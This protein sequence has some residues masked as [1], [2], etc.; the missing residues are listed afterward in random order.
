[1]RYE[2]EGLVIVSLFEIVASLL[3]LRMTPNLYGIWHFYA[4]IARFKCWLRARIA[5]IRMETS[6]Q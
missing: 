4:L 6:T 5:R 3:K 2:S 1:M